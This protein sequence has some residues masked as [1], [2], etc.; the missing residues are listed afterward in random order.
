MIQVNR[1]SKSYGDVRAL[2]RISFDLPQ[3]DVLVV[4]GPSGCG[5]TTLLRLIAGLEALDE[6]QVTIEEVIV[7]QPGHIVSPHLRSIGFVF[8]RSALWPHLTV[9][10]NVLFGV[11]G[12]GRSETT[13]LL[14]DLLGSV[15]LHGLAARHPSE[16]SGGEA[17]R[18]AIIRALAPRPRRLLMD[19]PLVNLEPDLK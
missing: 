14:E 3:G 10:Q 11:Q 12:I 7:S 16:L 19:E 8:Q 15:H 5:K 2:D 4:Q 9:A 17:R 6:G 1:V 13:R 18:V